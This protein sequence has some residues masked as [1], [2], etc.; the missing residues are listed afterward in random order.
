MFLVVYGKV[1]VEEVEHKEEDTASRGL[2]E[3]IKSQR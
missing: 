1:A 2:E 3:E